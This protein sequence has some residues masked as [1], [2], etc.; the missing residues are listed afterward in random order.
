MLGGIGGRRRRGWQRMRWLD[1]I[2]DSMD[3]SLS[4]LRGLVM[5][6]EAWHA[7]IHGV[8]KSWTRLSD[9]SDKDVL[10]EVPKEWFV[11][12][13]YQLGMGIVTTIFPRKI[14]KHCVMKYLWKKKM[15]SNPNHYHIM[16]GKKPLEPFQS[17]LASDLGSSPSF[18]N[19]THCTFNLLCEVWAVII[20]CFLIGI[21]LLY[22]VLLSCYTTKWISG[23]YT[24]TTSLSD[25]PLTPISPASCPSRSSRSTEQGS[26]CYTAG[27]V[28][29]L[30][31][32]Q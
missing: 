28:S 7:A 6:R 10:L 16:G 19:L 2:I 14:F 32:T 31:Y 8:T 12:Q 17:V 1:G 11:S 18:G 23:K 4:E 5:D 21:Q 3:V 22:N 26:L 29:Y 20:F 30:F 15:F 13:F 25:I 9:W 24:Y 27:P